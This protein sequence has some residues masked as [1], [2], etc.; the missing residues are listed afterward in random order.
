M[1]SPLSNRFSGILLG[2][3]LTLTTGFFATPANAIDKATSEK[4]RLQAINTVRYALPV[5]GLSR[6][7]SA[8][9]GDGQYLG[10]T[11]S[12]SSLGCTPGQ[13][14]PIR[15]LTFGCTHFDFQRNGSMNRMIATNEPTH[16]LNTIWTNKD[17]GSNALS[18]VIR[19]EGYDPDFGTLSDGSGGI[20]IACG[21]AGCIDPGGFPSIDSRGSNGLV[22]NSFHLDFSSATGDTFNSWAFYNASPSLADFVG[23][24]ID[25]ALVNTFKLG[26]TTSLKWPRVAYTNDGAGTEVTHLLINSDRT[27]A[28]GRILYIRKVGSGFTGTWDTPIEVGAGGFH[29]SG[30]ITASR[31]VG[32][33]KVVIAAAL[34]RGDGTQFGGYVRRF[35]GQISGQSDN[36][37]FYMESNDAGATWS[38]LANVTMRPDS[39]AH[40]GNP[41]FQFAPGTKLDVLYDQADVFHV[42]WQAAVWNGYQGPF[43]TQGRLFHYDPL[44]DKIRIVHDFVWNQTMCNGGLF[45]LNATNPQISEC[46]NKL[47]VTFEQ[48]NDIPNGIEDDCGERAPSAPDG[49]AN[50]DIYVT[51]SDNGGQNW[52]LKRN[53][54]STYTPNCDTIPGGANPDC[55]SDVWHSTTRYGIDIDV[56]LDDFDAIPDLSANIGGYA[57]SNYLFVQYVSDSDPGGAVNAEGGWTNNSL[58]VFRFGCVEKV[59]NCPI[60]TA[61]MPVG[62]IVDDPAFVL[63]GEDSVLSWVLTNVGNK[64]VNYS[65]TISNDF[66]VGNVTLTGAPLSGVISEGDPNFVVFLLTLNASHETEVQH[67]HAEFDIDGDFVEGACGTGPL[68]FVVDY[69]IGDLELRKSDTLGNRLVFSNQGGAGL[70]N[71][72]GIGGLTM[73]FQNTPASLECDTTGNADN[74]LFDASPIVSYNNGQVVSAMFSNSVVDSFQFRPLTSPSSDEVSNPDWFLGNSGQFTTQDSTLCFSI[75]WFSPKPTIFSNP[76]WKIVIG[77]VCYYN[78]S[79]S[80]IDSVF[81][82]YAWDWDVPSDTGVRNTSDFTFNNFMISM[83]G[84]EYGQDTGNTACIP[85]NERYAAVM[86]VP[87]TTNSLPDYTDGGSGVMGVGFQSFYTRDNAT[88]VGG[89]WDHAKLDSALRAIGGFSTYDSAAPDSQEVDLHLVLNGGAYRID[90]DDS[91]YLTFI[92]I[93]GI[94]DSESFDSC[95]SLATHLEP[96]VSPQW[97]TGCCVVAGDF[98]CDG[99][100]NIAD[101]TAEIAHIFAGGPGPCCFDSGDA[102]CDGAFNIADVTYS[103]NRIFGGGPAACCGTTGF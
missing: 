78:N 58:R 68:H 93:T 98:N 60:A 73:D 77:Q 90:S 80:P 39:L 6:S 31:K 33:Q 100:F 40:P 37:I 59:A 81:C 79:P 101:I 71:N 95:V 21:T 69:T 4:L 97:F 10:A 65:I 22:V 11:S 38:Q 89:S 75:D 17:N 62:Q 14:D 47:Y 61:S 55:D 88:F 63:P 66:P 53:L 20:G 28:D 82:A 49:A 57:G 32:S 18:Y 8:S 51:V 70:Q 52:D 9:T 26:N 46:D 67:A 25:T 87:T 43:T 27:D 92:M 45:N 30:A 23:Q 86:Y 36:D 29:L 99:A 83:R 19:Y 7:T 5:D 3:L 42:V 2:S 15:G 34:G 1:N 24:V 72:Q 64:P 50:G 44:K 48:F 102:N 103:I 56:N 41:V 13:Q 76:N 16:K 96:P 85:N 54:T 12:G 91:L 94:G 84:A 35:N 74:Y